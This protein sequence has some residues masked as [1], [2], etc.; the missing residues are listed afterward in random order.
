MNIPPGIEL[1]KKLLSLTTPSSEYAKYPS[2]HLVARFISD[3]RRAGIP[4]HRYTPVVLLLNRATLYII[5][6]ALRISL[7]YDL[8][9]G[10][11]FT[12]VLIVGK[13]GTG[14]STIG[15]ALAMSVLALGGWGDV[16]EP[17]RYAEASDNL[18]ETLVKMADKCDWDEYAEVVNKHLWAMSLIRLDL[19]FLFEN[20]PPIFFVD[21][22][23]RELGGY[24]WAVGGAARRLYV[25]AVKVLR[26]VKDLVGL[27]MGAVQVARS[28]PEQVRNLMDMFLFLQRGPSKTIETTLMGLE[29][30]E[31]KGK[32]VL[33]SIAI[34]GLPTYPKIAMHPKLWER[35]L[36]ERRKE[37]ERDQAEALKALEKIESEGEE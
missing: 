9:G 1:V 37:I 6:R 31:N 33:R 25:A 14:K 11:E 7:V 15:T 27:L 29:L 10:M 18:M 4:A 30:D 21:E 32:E 24:N 36:E 19:D 17:C 35:Y 28:V 34:S 3:A 13:P 12:S 26:F 16:A 8:T 5:A 22:M 23:W 2:A 20:R